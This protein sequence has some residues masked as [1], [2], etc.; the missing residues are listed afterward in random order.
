MYYMARL[1]NPFTCSQ[2]PPP[3]PSFTLETYI[4]GV[5]MRVGQYFLHGKG[6]GASLLALAKHLYKTLE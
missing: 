3:P 5:H 4:P 2:D 6:E 1:G